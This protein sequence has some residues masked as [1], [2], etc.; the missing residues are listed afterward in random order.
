MILHCPIKAMLL[1][2][3]IIWYYA[4]LHFLKRFWWLGLRNFAPYL[5][6]F[7]RI[8]K[9]VDLFWLSMR[10][11][12][13]RSLCFLG[14]AFDDVTAAHFFFGYFNK[15]K[16][17]ILKIQQFHWN[18]REKLGCLIPNMWIF[19]KTGLELEGLWLTLSG[20]F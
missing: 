2:K 5:F 7:A 17:N 4:M 1:L 11:L 3:K 10:C 14:W 15:K 16:L 18:P 6:W 19:T 8:L 20:V 13:T 9:F 12:S